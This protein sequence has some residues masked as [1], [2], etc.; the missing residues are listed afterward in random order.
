M[1]TVEHI[2]VAQPGATEH[3][4]PLRA[5]FPEVTWTTLLP[6]TPG[7]D[8]DADL[9][10]RATVLFADFPPAKVASMSSLRWMQLGSHGYAQLAGTRLPAGVTVAG[11]GGVNGIPI[12][13]WCVLMLL[14]LARN[15]PGMLA[16]QRE[17]RWDRSA[18][19]QTEIT[20]R[21]VGILGYGSVGQE[22][23]RQMR[24]LG[25]EVWVMS[26]SDTR[27]GRLRFDPRP[28]EPRA[29]I[30][31]R[32]FGFGEAQ[33]FYRGVDVLVVALPIASGTA[34]LVD[35]AALS[36]LPRGALLLNPARAGV[37]DE[38]ALLDALRSGMLGGAALDDH[39]RQ[40]MPADDPFFDLPTTIVTSHI[41]GSTGS[42]F[43]HERIWRLLAEN[44]A[45]HLRGEALLNVIRPEDLELA[46]E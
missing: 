42:S 32:S 10:A 4:P 35:R 7:W 28:G 20:G 16:A 13:Q 23:A 37:V 21:R 6:S 44:L 2:V 5:R 12:A 46:T 30:P 27:T 39:Y 15:L 22:V 3:L 18:I 11:G 19:F 38:A 40:P 34:G 25:L 24:A 33:Q 1:T 36:L 29:I 8:L 17:H 31:D 26:R 41:S 9:A 43:Y 45:R 14:A